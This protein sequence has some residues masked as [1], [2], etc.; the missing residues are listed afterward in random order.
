MNPVAAAA[1]ATFGPLFLKSIPQGAAT[2][3]FVA[4]HP[5]LAGVSGEYFADCNVA[6]PRADASDAALA[7]RLWKTSERIVIERLAQPG[8]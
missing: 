4:T 1:Y 7:E 6:R 3:V 2:E 5:S 8:R